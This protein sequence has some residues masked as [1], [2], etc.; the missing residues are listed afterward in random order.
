M[1]STDIALIIVIAAVSM[2]IAYFG[3]NALLGDPAEKYESVIYM[4]TITS[5]LPDPDPETFNAYAL[6][7]TVEVYV[8]DCGLGEVWDEETLS[9]VEDDGDN[10]EET[11][12]EE[13]TN[14]EE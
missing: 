2:V 13:N 10:G 1:K 8:G 14:T 6:N 5:E 12:D 3:G 9:C 7:P 4:D 11:P